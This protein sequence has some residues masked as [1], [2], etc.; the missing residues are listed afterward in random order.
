MSLFEIAVKGGPLMIVLLILS[1]VSVAIILERLLN[2]KKHK[3]LTHNFVKEITKYLSE[4][5]LKDAVSLCKINGE[6]AAARII[7]KTLNA[8]ENGVTEMEKVM[9]LAKK[10]EM[11]SMEK[12]LGTLAT[13]SA[14]APLIGFLGTV[15][16]MVKVFMKIAETGGGVDINLLASGIWEALITTI[17]GLAVGIV[18]ILFYNYIVGVIEEIARKIDDYTGEIIIFIRSNLN[19]TEPQ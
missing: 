1:I 14:V 6:N 4:G 2:L 13:F 7:A 19:A 12:N 10:G 8:Y 5:K 15:T 17:G 3:R 9:D 16:G 18:T 11:H